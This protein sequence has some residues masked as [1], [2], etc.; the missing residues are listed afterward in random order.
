MLILLL[1]LLLFD[2]MYIIFDTSSYSVSTAMRPINLVALALSL[3]SL[4]RPDAT[5]IRVLVLVRYIS[6]VA[7]VDDDN[8]DE[9]DDEY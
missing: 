9:Y 1:L 2:K 4:P 7:A 8:A 6:L 5:A 3:P